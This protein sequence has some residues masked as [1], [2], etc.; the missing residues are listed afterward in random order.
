[1][2]VP[3]YR[4]LWYP[5][6][7]QSA[8]DHAALQPDSASIQIEPALSV[9]ESQQTGIDTQ[10]WVDSEATAF[11]GSSPVMESSKSSGADASAGRNGAASLG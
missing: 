5:D 8:A 1:M 3:S 6:S 10:G 7:S 9:G 4:P 11:F 2:I